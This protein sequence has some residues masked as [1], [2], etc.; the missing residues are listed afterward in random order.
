MFAV[1]S[2]GVARYEFHYSYDYALP[3]GYADGFYSFMRTRRVVD[4]QTQVGPR[5]LPLPYETRAALDTTTHLAFANDEMQAG[6]L[7]G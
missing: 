2:P 7:S 1:G 4:A 3:E 6:F 5:W